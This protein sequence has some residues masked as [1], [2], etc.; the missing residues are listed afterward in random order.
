LK[1]DITGIGLKHIVFELGGRGKRG[2]G[3][4]YMVLGLTFLCEKM[5]YC[6][7]KK[8]KWGGGGTFSELG[9]FKGQ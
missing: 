6:W 8:E 5:K 7:E 3:V 4:I 2:D 9:I 1:K